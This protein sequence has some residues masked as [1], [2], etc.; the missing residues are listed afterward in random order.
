VR[1]PT[2]SGEELDRNETQYQVTRHRL[3]D[4]AVQDIVRERVLGAEARRQGKT[5]E[6]LIA[7]E[8]G[9]SLEPSDVEIATWYKENPDRVGGRTL[10]QV[11]P[12]IADYLRGE[13]RKAATEKLTTRLNRERQVVVNVEPYRVALSNDGAPA[14]GPADARVTL[15]EF[16]DFQC[17]FCQRFV[18]TLKAV[19]RQYG[20]RVRIVYRQYP[21]PNLHADAMKAAEASL[22]ANEQGKF[23]EL[24]DAM[25][26]AQQQLAIRDLKAKA[27][28][29]GL[30]QKKFDACLD[31]GRYTERV[32]QD[33]AEGRR[34]GVTGTP[35][36]F[37]NG[38][39]LE[40]GAVPLN[41]LT[42]AI[43]KELARTTR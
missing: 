15:V 12:Q 29:L 22:C 37:L 4:A 16:S 26:E 28:R 7:G 43:E 19:E 6:D 17:P 23:W 18:P 21:I 8:A 13:R 41:V 40:G 36:I 5:I 2:R 10:E 3:V 11:R 24:H 30:D 20:D 25:F 33:M 14:K 31:T 1:P 9:G 27:G 38:V 35:A 39:Q 42:A 34:V 32:Q